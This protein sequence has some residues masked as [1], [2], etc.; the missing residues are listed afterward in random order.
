VARGKHL[1]AV[2]G[3]ERD[4]VAQSQR[5]DSLDGVPARSA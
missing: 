3:P 2:V 1:A 4:L 5:A